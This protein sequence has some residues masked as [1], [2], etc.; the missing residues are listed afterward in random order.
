M[1]FEKVR[2]IIAEQVNV[3]KDAIKPDSTIE[4]LKIDSLD[5]VEVIMQ[6]EEA[7][8]ITIDEDVQVATVQDLVSYI[9][10]QKA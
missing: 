5:M 8:S 7:F 1:I 3:D 2:D 6:L 10:T 9:E 4:Q